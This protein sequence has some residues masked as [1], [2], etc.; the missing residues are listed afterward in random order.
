MPSLCSHDN[1]PSSSAENL[2]SRFRNSWITPKSICSLSV[3]FRV[4]APHC[5]CSCYSIIT[6]AKNTNRNRAINTAP[7]SSLSKVRLRRSVR[8]RGTSQKSSVAPSLKGKTLHFILATTF[9]PLNKLFGASFSSFF[10]VL[11]YDLFPFL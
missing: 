10:V 8:R 6:P 5:L 3:S 1:F 11:G 2:L 4:K 7:E 9:F